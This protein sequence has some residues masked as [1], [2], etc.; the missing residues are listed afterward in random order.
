MG[1]FRFEKGRKQL[2]T[3]KPWT[4]RKEKKLPEVEMEKKRLRIL[5]T[6]CISFLKVDEYH[7]KHFFKK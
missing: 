2:K 1:R 6:N 3:G 7:N 5:M 4:P